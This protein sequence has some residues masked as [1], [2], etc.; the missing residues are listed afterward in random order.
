[1]KVVETLLRYRGKI[2]ED[3]SIFGSEQRSPNAYYENSINDLYNKI[4]QVT[5]LIERI[6][7]AGL[8]IYEINTK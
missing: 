2:I 5:N 8:N 1:M 3:I 4:D 6:Q 7:A